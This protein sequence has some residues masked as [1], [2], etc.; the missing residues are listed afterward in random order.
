M[1]KIGEME[2]D[3]LRQWIEAI[4]EQKLL[5]MLGDPD[6]GLT[7]RPEIAERVRRTL[8]EIARGQ[9]FMP[10]QE[11]AKELGLEWRIGD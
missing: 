6:E 8:V 1:P 9:T 3:E 5:E 7:L 10:A 4:V 2:L 11:V